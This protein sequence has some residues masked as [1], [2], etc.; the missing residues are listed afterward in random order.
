M[1]T[2]YPL[3]LAA[4]ALSL[5][6][7]P[8]CFYVK[9]LTSRSPGGNM[10]SDDTFT[11]ISTPYEPLTLT[12]YDTRDNEPLWTVDV[13]INSKVTVRFRENKIKEGTPR[14][15]DIMDWV[16][17]DQEDRWERLE[18]SMAVPP[19]WARLLRVSLRSG[20]EYPPPPIEDKTFPDPDETWAPVGDRETYRDNSE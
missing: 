5:A 18:N 12:L 7:M 4:L 15:P 9:Q 10:T 6:S 19:A 14:R 8:G 16:I 17:F 13:P 20:P 2:R 11:Y 3:A 1:P